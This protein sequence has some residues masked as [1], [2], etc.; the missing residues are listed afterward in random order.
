MRDWAICNLQDANHVAGPQ[1]MSAPGPIME[2]RGSGGDC[3]KQ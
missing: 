1:G 2:S 3:G